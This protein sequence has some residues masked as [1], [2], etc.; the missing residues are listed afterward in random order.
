MNRAKVTSRRDR[1]VY[2]LLVAALVVCLSIPLLLH[3]R[4][5]LFPAAHAATDCFR[6]PDRPP[7]FLTD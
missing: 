7:L 5:I 6:G 1:I 3:F 2:G 4:L